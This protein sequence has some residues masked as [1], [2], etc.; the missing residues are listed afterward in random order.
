MKL[1]KNVVLII[2]FFGLV[3]NNYGEIF[4]KFADIN[5]DYMNRIKGKWIFSDRNYIYEFTDTFVRKIDGFLYYRY[6]SSKYPRYS[7]FIY[8]IFKSKKTG[9]SYFCRGNWNKNRGFIHVSSRIRFIGED[10]F[11][12]YSKD[13]NREIYFTAKRIE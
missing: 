7:N 8:A 9:V 10:K 3:G 6:K 1:L 5:K 13:D 2:L 11:I 4:G 12:V